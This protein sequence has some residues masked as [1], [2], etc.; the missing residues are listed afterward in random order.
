[1]RS[2][3]ALAIAAT[4]SLRCPRS[5]C[6]F[7]QSGIDRRDL[8]GTAP[9][10]YTDDVV[11][12][13]RRSFI[14]GQPLSVAGPRGT[15]G[16]GLRVRKAP[17]SGTIGADQIDL[18]RMHRRKSAAAFW[19]C[20]VAVGREGNPFSVRRPAGAKIT[21][22]MI[23]QVAS[24]FVASSSSQMSACL[25]RLETKARYLLSGDNTP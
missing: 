18:G 14:K 12:L 8:R 11:H 5:A 13:F 17:Q 2:D 4:I 23:R 7:R 1:M 6:A 9:P 24:F 20:R 25:L 19:R 21:R 15:A 10:I 22:R 16:E 3:P